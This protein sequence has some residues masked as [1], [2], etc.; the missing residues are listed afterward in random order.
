MVRKSKKNTPE[1]CAKEWI[2]LKARKNA[3]ENRL[4]KLKV[5]LEPHLEAQ[6]HMRAELAGW[7]FRINRKKRESFKLKDAKKEVDLEVLSPFITVS[8]YNEIRTTYL[9]SEK[10]A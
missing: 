10:A 7:E 9:A 2:V 3:I 1:E 6:P 5:V 8:E 4:E